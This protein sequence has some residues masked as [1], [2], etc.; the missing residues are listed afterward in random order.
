MKNIVVAGTGTGVG[1]TLVATILA[2]ALEADYWKPVQA[3]NLSFSDTDYVRHFIS[4]TKSYFHPEVYRL[5]YAMSPHA[6]AEKEEVKIEVE[7]LT[8]PKSANRILIEP[9]GGLMVPLNDEYLN[10][11]LIQRWRLP[12]ILVSKTYLGSI[13]HTLMSVTVLKKYG[14]KIAGVIFNGEPN[15]P[16]ERAILQYSGVKY[17]G[18][19]QE[20]KAIN[21]K[22]VLKYAE[23]FRKRLE[24]VI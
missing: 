24:G 6:A 8:P 14:V 3:G 7:Q 23:K 21:K 9:A 12:V 10:I 17:L 19:L 4:N 2:E 11:D 5:A 13:N 15:E 18:R 1:K 20:E 22:T 16:A